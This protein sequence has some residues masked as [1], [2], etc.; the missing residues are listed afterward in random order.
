MNAFLE[1]LLKLSPLVLKYGELGAKVL[2]EVVKAIRLWLA[3]DR[4]LKNAEKVN[5]IKAASDRLNANILAAE[6]ESK[7]NSGRE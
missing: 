2:N 3:K 1:L 4:G 7:D 5:D 6:Q